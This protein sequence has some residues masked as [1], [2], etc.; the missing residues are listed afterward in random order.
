MKYSSLHIS[1]EDVPCHRNQDH[2]TQAN[3]SD[4]D[5]LIIHLL[6]GIRTL[7]IL[8]I[9]ISVTIERVALSK[10]LAFTQNGQPSR[11]EADIKTPCDKMG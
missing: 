5:E 7:I 4:E 8:S 6:A 3:F 11:Y 2:V 1:R 9:I 10:D